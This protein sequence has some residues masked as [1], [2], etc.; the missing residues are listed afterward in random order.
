MLVD[1]DMLTSSSSQSDCSM[2]S[3]SAIG[4]TRGATATGFDGDIEPGEHG[5]KD[6][7]MN[8]NRSARAFASATVEGI[9]ELMVHG[10]SRVA[11][12]SFNNFNN[13]V[14]TKNPSHT[15]CV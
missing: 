15:S 4:R 7:S 10:A 9:D 14:R 13:F 3:T 6:G 12:S 5:S 11:S 2:A 8:R 1:V